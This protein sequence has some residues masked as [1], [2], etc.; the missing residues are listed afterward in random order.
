MH[1]AKYTYCCL[2]L[3]G[4]GGIEQDA[5]L[6]LLGIISSN[7]P[8][9]ANHRGWFAYIRGVFKQGSKNQIRGSVPQTNGDL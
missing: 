7:A 8:D 5:L 1:L 9:I 3:G 6:R 2:E 4:V